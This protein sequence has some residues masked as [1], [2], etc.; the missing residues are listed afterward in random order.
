[1]IRTIILSI[2]A[3]FLFAVNASATEATVSLEKSFLVAAHHMDSK[4]SDSSSE[5]KSDDNSSDD[6]SSDDGSSDDGSS[7]D[8]SGDSKS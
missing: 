6:G 5:D 7:D 2:V 3:C 8:K 4:S 1:M